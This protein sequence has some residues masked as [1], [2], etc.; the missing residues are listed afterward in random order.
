M[1]KCSFKKGETR[2][3]AMMDTISNWRLIENPRNDRQVC[4]PDPTRG[5]GQQADPWLHTPIVGFERSMMAVFYRL[6]GMR[7]QTKTVG[8]KIVKRGG[9]GEK[10]SPSRRPCSSDR[11]RGESERQCT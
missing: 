10:R 6:Q 7:A 3:F 8:K 4:T 1:H 9:G 2:S 5:T 11:G